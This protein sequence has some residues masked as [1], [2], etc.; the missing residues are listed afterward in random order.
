[1]TLVLFPAFN[2]GRTTADSHPLRQ[3]Y[4]KVS[5]AAQAE[6]I[7]VLDLTPAYASATGDG[8]WRQWW[9]TPYDRHPNA[10]AHLLAARSIARH[11]VERGWGRAH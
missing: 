10:Q 7:D 3:V 9:A 6:G 11:L 5:R 2:P 1:V 8:D 4:A